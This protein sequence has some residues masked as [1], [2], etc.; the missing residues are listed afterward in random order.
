M[1]SLT[2][3]TLTIAATSAGWVYMARSER[4]NSVQSEL[5]MDVRKAMEKLKRDLRLSSIDKIV[6]YPSGPGPYSA[7]SF[8][9]AVDDNH[10]GVI[11]LGGGSSNIL[12]D[13][14]VVY[15]V[16]TSTPYRLL[17][18]MFNTRNNNLTDVQRISQL[19]S[20]VSNGHGRVTY[21]NTNTTTEAIFE[22][23]FTW[24]IFGRGSTYDGYSSAL[25]RDVALSFGSIL[26]TNGAHTFKFT[27]IGKNAASSG[28]RI[29]I[30]TLAVSPCGVE[31]EAEAQLPVTAQSGA[32]AAAEYMAQGS[33]GG[34]YQ[35]AFPATATG[36][37]FTLTMDND[38]WEETNFRGA[39]ALCSRTLVEF[40]EYSSPKDFIV[41][42]EGPGYA[43][44]ADGQTR[45]SNTYV[46]G[47]SL[48]GTAVRLLVRG[49]R[50]MENGGAIQFSG[51]THYVLFMAAPSG[52]L[53]IRA[54]FIAEVADHT[55]YTPDAAVNGTRLYF[56][57]T[58]YSGPYSRED[59]TIPA[60]SSWWA[61]T[62]SG[63]EIDSSKS[64]LVTF[65]LGGADAQTYYWPETNP[66][67]PGAYIL[68][69]TEHPTPDTCR[70]PVWSTKPLT[71][72]DNLYAVYGIYTT[73]PTNGTFTSQ[74]FD[75]KIAAPTY[76]AISWNSE[77]PSGTDLKI[78]V[79]TGSNEAMSGAPAWSNVTAMVPPASLSPGNG[80]YVQ[81]QALFSPDTSGWS[82]PKLKDLK[83]QWVGETRIVDIGATV[84]KGPNYGIVELTVDGRQLVKGIR[85]DLTIY[86]DVLGFGS[87]TKR[88]TSSMTAEV[89]PRNTGM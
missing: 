62:A 77:K 37:S 79:R 82:T 63:Y 89:N 49:S 18:T 26:L 70:D 87:T 42:L 66:G 72:S 64:Y 84:T 41:R 67:A 20:V 47:N 46:S 71:V 52:P 24:S 68:P 19:A 39:G 22:N 44:T 38:R 8:P 88:L 50:Q 35:L 15:H 53:H 43:W 83:I 12:W 25:D 36:Q 40:D 85:V 5:D 86:K 17:R 4:L 55:H 58:Q 78:K 2:V 9:L 27:T 45:A 81:F 74:V 31:R 75:T 54:A 56:S 61:C 65:L 34:N 76:T 73:Y 3:V 29:G 13:K 60:G 11:E 10:D 59:V 7:I 28:Y 32:S 80:R 51:K 69:E 6:Y 16:W 57:N 14:T 48:T 23:L 21:E 30:D 1:V 33:W